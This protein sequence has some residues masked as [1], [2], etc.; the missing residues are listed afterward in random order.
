VS[1]DVAG[2]S[3][4]IG[5]DET[6][7]LARLRKNRSEQHPDSGQPFFATTAHPYAVLLN[8]L[9]NSGQSRLNHCQLLHCLGSLSAGRQ[10]FD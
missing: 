1:A 7:T 6:G 4:L 5:R 8:F 3:R 10:P 2:Y 9:A